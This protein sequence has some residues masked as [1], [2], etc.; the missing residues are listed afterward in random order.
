LERTLNFLACRHVE[1]V[2]RAPDQVG[3]GGLVIADLMTQPNMAKGFKSAI[4][5]GRYAILIAA[6]LK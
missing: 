4:R 2:D 6:P 3:L 1:V 5:V